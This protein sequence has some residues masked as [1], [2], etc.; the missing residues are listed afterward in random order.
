VTARLFA[1]MVL[2]AAVAAPAAAVEPTVLR[3]A[4][5]APDGTGWARLFR[6][7][8]REIAA[9]S[10]G[11]VTSK[12]YFGGI[13][14]NEMQMLDRLQRGQLDVA[15]SGGM[16]CMKLSP[17]M[18]A[19]RLLGLFQSRD[20][21]SY[22]LGRLRP[23]IDADLAKAGFHNVAEAGL[24]SDMIFSRR[25]ITT[26]AEL[27]R[28]RLW[29]W[30]LDEPMKRQLA[31]M[32][33]PGVALPVEQAAHAYEEGRIDGFL[34]V[35][36]AALAF[37]WSAQAAYLS[38]LRLA[39]LPAC[40]FV[41]NRAWDALSNEG[42]LALTTVSAKMQARLEQLGRQQDAALIGG[43]LERQGVKMTPAGQGFT[44]E[45]FEAARTAR[46]ALRDKLIPGDLI[47]RVT[48]WVADYR[49]QYGGSRG[50]R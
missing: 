9:E 13:A 48:G 42:R 21:A 37:Q 33:V 31:A 17:A 8:S 46:D 23:Q 45:F 28:A 1:V 35:P 26:M 32:R 12:W 6:T 29:Y 10:H 43:L 34:A 15:M 20:E 4:T 7:M 49:A 47:D 44:A 2:V 40:M 24:G 50:G 36:T 5:V 22:V 19:L 3:F 18:R 27:R 25:P 38:R 39:Y 30:D 11:E 14:G 16:L 41:T